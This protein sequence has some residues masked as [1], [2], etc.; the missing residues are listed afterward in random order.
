MLFKNYCT[1]ILII[2]YT[3]LFY[4]DPCT[5]RFLVLDK[6]LGLYTLCS[7]SPSQPYFELLQ[8]SFQELKSKIYR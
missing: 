5:R 4:Q 7:Q 1:I 8:A 3:C 6:P 2:I